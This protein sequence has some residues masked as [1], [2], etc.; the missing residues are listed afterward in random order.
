MTKT[1]APLVGFMDHLLDAICVVDEE[2]RFIFVN[3]AGERVFAYTP[4]G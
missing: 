1:F 2:G 3:A 4:N